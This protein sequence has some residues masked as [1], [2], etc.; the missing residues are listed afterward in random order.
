MERETNAN[1]GQR[2]EQYIDQM[3]ERL[4]NERHRASFAMYAMGL[5]SGS[6]RKSMEPIAAQ[7]APKHTSAAHQRLHHF[8]A[9]TSWSDHEVRLAAARYAIAAMEERD[10]VVAWVIDDTGFL[11][12]GKNSVGVQRQYTGSA[13]KT[14]NCQIG[15][16]LSV[17]TRTEH[18]PIDFALFLPESWT[19]DPERRLKVKIPEETTFQPKHDLA[20]GMIEQAVRDQIP[21]RIVLGDAFY[22][23][24]RP[25]RE[26]VHLLGFDYGLAIYSSD[27]MQLVD[28]HER[29]RGELRT[30]KEIALALGP[31]AFRRCTWREGTNRK[32][33]SRFALC[34]VKVPVEPGLAARAEWLLVEWPS[35]DKEPTHFFLTTL[36]RT[37]SK[38]EIVRLIKERYRTEQVYEE[39]K[40]ELG[41]DH[42]EGRSFPGW[43]HHVSV[44][45]CVYAFLVAE[46]SRAFPPRPE[47]RVI[48]VRSVERPELH[49]PDSI[50]TVRRT[51]VRI[52]VRWLPRCPLCHHEQPARGSDAPHSSH[53]SM[54]IGA[55]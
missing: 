23:H 45:L 37:M 19:Q 42:F 41:L 20:L 4:G 25:F 54:P 9:N 12:Q 28:R 30:A 48:P 21:G 8:I 24:S 13:G 40:G 15:V 49:F 50:P 51:F 18:L 17:T 43:H 14:A 3:G 53:A 27:T 2:L 46:R 6:E 52:V 5:L 26:T 10:P 11:K 34:R 16:S 47:G 39:L 7:A 32:L 1:A 22:G 36:P 31:K 35:G 33:S 38:K 55:P 44:V 29:A